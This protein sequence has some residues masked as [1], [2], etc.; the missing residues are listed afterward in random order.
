M[1]SFHMINIIVFKQLP[2]MCVDEIPLCKCRRLG[3]PKL[4]MT[5]LGINLAV[6]TLGLLYSYCL[7]LISVALSCSYDKWNLERAG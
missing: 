5:L 1:G 2:N 4:S 7:D 3:M 6:T